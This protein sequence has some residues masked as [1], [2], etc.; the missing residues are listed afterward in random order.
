MLD[1]LTRTQRRVGAKPVGGQ[2]SC[3]GVHE[4]RASERVFVGRLAE[5]FE[6]VDPLVVA[7][8]AQ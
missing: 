3:N 5:A 6:R 2:P 7:D 1:A 8:L 4:M